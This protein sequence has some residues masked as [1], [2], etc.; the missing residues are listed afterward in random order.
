MND[1]VLFLK[2]VSS[3]QLFNNFFPGVVFVT[4]LEQYTR[5]EILSGSV[6]Q[7]VFVYY[8]VGMVLSRVGSLLM[9]PWFK[10]WKIVEYAKYEDY[11]KA[12]RQE[13]KLDILTETNNTFRTL[14]SA[15][16]CLMV[17]SLIGECM[18]A[19]QSGDF[20]LDGIFLLW[21]LLF[22]LFV[23]SFRKQTS[24]IR[25]LVEETNALQEASKPAKEPAG[26][27]DGQEKA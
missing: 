9:E 12:R 25:K 10:C 23:V 15:F 22:V 26:T 18:N 24:Y 1:L 4:F 19:C 27:G 17:A 3:Y 11:N 5:F 14:A 6:L 20:C 2:K 21:F 13:A 16:L 7:Q 8:F